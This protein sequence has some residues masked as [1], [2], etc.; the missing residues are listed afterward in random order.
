[1]CI[2]RCGSVE[3]GG[4]NDRPRH[5]SY[6]PGIRRS[7]TGTRESHP[8][9]GWENDEHGSPTSHTRSA[10]PAR[11]RSTAAARSGPDH[12]AARLVPRE[13]SIC[14]PTK[15]TSAPASGEY[16]GGNASGRSAPTTR[17]RQSGTL[18]T[19]LLPLP[20]I[21]SDILSSQEERMPTVTAGDREPTSRSGCS[22]ALPKALRPI[23]PRSSPWASNGRLARRARPTILF[24]SR[25]LPDIGR[26]I[27]DGWGCPPT[28]D[29]DR[30]S[31]RRCG[32]DQEHARSG[33]RERGRSRNERTNQPPLAA[34]AE[35]SSCRFPTDP[36]TRSL[37]TY[38]L[39]LR[40]TIPRPR[41]P[42][43]P[44]S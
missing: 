23:G 18:L 15:A 37:F 39:S 31:R 14:P 32:S 44:G 20:R 1:M 4:S 21:Y 34:R 35:P 33:T 10:E 25:P 40:R 30:I 43:W 36:S 2:A 16:E 17:P 8:A 5:R 38:L 6:V 19:L 28:R 22:R 11:G 24:H 7:S 13:R 12:V 29:A 42:S 9:T 41:S 27:G 3:H 26:G